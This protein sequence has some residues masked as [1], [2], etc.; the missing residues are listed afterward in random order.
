MESPIAGTATWTSAHAR[1]AAISPRAAASRAASGAGRRPVATLAVLP[2]DGPAGPP[3]RASAARAVASPARSA[4]VVAVRWRGTRR[5]LAPR[6]SGSR[7]P[8]ARAL[9]LPLSLSPE[10]YLSPFFGEAAPLAKR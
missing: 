2:Q 7:G 6:G 5:R 8:E 9:L 4:M 3:A 10:E 1:D